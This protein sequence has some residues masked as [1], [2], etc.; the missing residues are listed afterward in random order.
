VHVA[1]CERVLGKPLPKG[2]EVHHVDNDGHNFSRGNLVICP[3]HAYHY[4]LHKRQAAFDA[5]GHY[6]WGKCW[7][8]KKWGPPTEVVVRKTSYHRAC[9]AKYM[10]RNKNNFPS[11]SAQ[12][13]RKAW[14]RR[15]RRIAKVKPN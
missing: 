2:A 12:A 14:K 10:Q 11:R 5:C 4:H 3:S 15:K 13:Q 6:D 7:L 8:C 1:I 9:V